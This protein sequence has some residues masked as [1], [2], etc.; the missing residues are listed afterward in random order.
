V[1]RKVL[2]GLLVISVVCISGCG[3]LLLSSTTT[4]DSN[5]YPARNNIGSN[6]DTIGTLNNADKLLIEADN[7]DL[8]TASSAYSNESSAVYLRNIFQ[9]EQK[10]TKLLQEI[11][12][13]LEHKI[14]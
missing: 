8:S 1:I 11:K 14:S 2:M 12:A 7:R 13:D 3:P 5:N 9:E 10:Q 6:I 4:T